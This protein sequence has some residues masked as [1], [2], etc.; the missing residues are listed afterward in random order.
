[1][2]WDW[3]PGWRIAFVPFVI[4]SIVWTGL[5]LWHAARRAEK[6]WFV[7]F[8]LV[9]TAGILEIIYLAFVVKLFSTPTRK[10]PKVSRKQ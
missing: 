3:V 2:P 8:F 5:A 10:P 1:M 6:W 7:L 9:H 4:W